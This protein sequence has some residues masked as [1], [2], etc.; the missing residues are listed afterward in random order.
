IRAYPNF[1]DNIKGQ[2][3]RGTFT[4]VEVR[5]GWGRL[6]NGIGWIWLEEEAYCTILD[7][8][9]ADS[10]EKKSID[11]VAMEVIN[12]KWGNGEE[13]KR[14]LTEAGYDYYAVQKRVNE[15]IWY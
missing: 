14:R 15:L 5:N 13:R 1:G 2:T 7:H 3:G 4:I 10:Y 6:K 9:V 12:G 8:I 11:E